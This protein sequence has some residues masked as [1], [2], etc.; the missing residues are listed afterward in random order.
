MEKQVIIISSLAED[1]SIRAIERI[2]GIHRDTIMRLGVGVGESCTRLLDS[3][4]RNLNSEAVE[5]DEIWGFIGKKQKNV[6]EEDSQDLGDV[7]TF[8]AVDADTKIVPCFRVGKRTLDHATDF[9]SDL[10]GRMNNRIQ[11]SSDGLAAYTEAVEQSFGADVDYGQTIKTYATKDTYPE[12]KYSPGDVT[13]VRKTV[14]MGMPDLNRISTS[15]VEAQNLTVRM[16]VRRLTR[17]TNAFSKKLENFK[18]AMGL[19]FAYQNFVKRHTSLRMTPAMA[20]GLT[21]SFWSVRQL[22]ERAEAV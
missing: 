15:Y 21:P 18:A 9:I 14:V 16:H 8:I 2:T 7:W 10:A 5:V 12:G 6:T 17:L 4:M 19:H 1:M 11:L 3:T 13:S 22:I 20:A